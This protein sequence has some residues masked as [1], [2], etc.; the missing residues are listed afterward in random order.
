MENEEKI[1]IAG[2]AALF[3]AARLIASH[4]GGDNN[5]GC[6]AEARVFVDH[7]KQE[8]LWPEKE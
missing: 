1:I 3:K 8:G 4:G 5:G 6:I 7:L 2:L